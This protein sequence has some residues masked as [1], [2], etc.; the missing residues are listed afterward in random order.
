M[1]HNCD[2]GENIV[3]TKVP[4]PHIIALEQP[5]VTDLSDFEP[6][7]A[8]IAHEADARASEACPQR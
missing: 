6:L 2:H 4:Q 7:R 8:C 3:G 1:E 5:L